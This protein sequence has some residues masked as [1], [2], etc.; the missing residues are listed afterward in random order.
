MP[1]LR[2]LQRRTEELFL[3]PPAEEAVAEEAEVRFSPFVPE[4][5]EG[6]LELVERWIALVEAG[7]GNAGLEEALEDAAREIAGP[8]PERAK[9]AMMIFITHYPKAAGLPIPALE[10]RR[11]ELAA[12]AAATDVESLEAVGGEEQLDWFREDPLANQHHEHWHVVYPVRGIPDPRG[13][14]TGKDRQGELFFY[15]HQ[16]MLARYDAERLA[17]GLRPVRPLATYTGPIAEGYD[18]GLPDFQPRSPGKRLG[19]V[20][21]GG[22][23]YTVQQHSRLRD[24]IKRV[25]DSGRFEDGSTVEPDALGAAVEP[26]VRR[27]GPEGYGNFHGFGHVLIAL[28]E[29]PNDTQ[30]PGVM[31]TTATAI[32]DPVFYRWHRHVDDQLFRWQERQPPQDFSDA[33]E[34]TATPPLL[35]FN[36]AVPSGSRTGAALQTWAK[37]TFGGAKWAD[38]FEGSPLVTAEL[39]TGFRTRNTPA[40]PLQYLDHRGFLYVLRLENAG[41]QAADVTVRLFLAPTAAAGDRRV[42]IEMDKFHHRLGPREKAVVARSEALSSVVQKPAVRPPRPR[43]DP[44]VDPQAAENYCNCGWPFHLLVP[45]GT[46]E[47]MPFRLLVMLTDWSLDQVSSAAHCGSMSFCGVRDAS[48]PDKRPMGYPFDR[49]LPA[50]IDEL[51]E[52]QPNM[53]LRDLTIRFKTRL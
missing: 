22:G 30:R 49:R 38:P 9:H 13:G 16:Q 27:G 7:R 21:L 52:R 1:R 5:V 39:E 8:Q 29:N 19:T 10:E 11:P 6:A 20:D 42:W 4:H 24:R 50:P 35:V 17:A 25:V 34:V 31:W 44:T 3:A 12:K 28:A 40:G 47:G 18:S 15:M 37:R 2:E 43:R 32:M 41:A 26:S 23:P 45:R 14:R 36:D 48:Y 46:P 53:A 51:V 33:P